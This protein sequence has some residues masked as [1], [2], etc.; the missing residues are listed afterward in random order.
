MHSRNARVI[1][2]LERVTYRSHIAIGA[3][4]DIR[5]QGERSI[6]EEILFGVNAELAHLQ[7]PL[8]VSR[9]HQLSSD[10]NG[11]AVSEERWGWF[12]RLPGAVPASSDPDETV[13]IDRIGVTPGAQAAEGGVR[14]NGISYPAPAGKLEISIAMLERHYPIFVTKQERLRVRRELLAEGRAGNEPGDAVHHAF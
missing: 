8:R 5:I 13:T 4:L 7:R 12:P 10:A 2:S 9:Q 3:L 6:T 14:Q 1:E 11:I